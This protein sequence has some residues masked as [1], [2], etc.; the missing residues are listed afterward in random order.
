M[1]V[2]ERLLEEVEH[3]RRIADQLQHKGDS[4]NATAYA[5]AS[6]GDEQYLNFLKHTTLASEAHGKAAGYSSAAASLLSV[7]EEIKNETQF[8]NI[9]NNA[10]S[11]D[12]CICCNNVDAPKSET[13]NS[14]RETYVTYWRGI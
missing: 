8:K 10:G 5:Y 12:K 3:Y 4:L 14:Y 2:I 1:N 9:N 13:V 7:V 6:K 11:V